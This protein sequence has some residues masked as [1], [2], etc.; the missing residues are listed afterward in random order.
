M[1]QGGITDRIKMGDAVNATKLHPSCL[2]KPADYALKY[3]MGD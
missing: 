3:N 2:V 1:G